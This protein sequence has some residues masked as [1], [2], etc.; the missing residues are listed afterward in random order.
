VL[1]VFLNHSTSNELHQILQDI[2]AIDNVDRVEWS[3]I[4]EVTTEN[5]AGILDII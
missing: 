3:E 4:V 5:K 1:I 2:R